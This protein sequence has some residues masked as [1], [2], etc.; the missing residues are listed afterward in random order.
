MGRPIDHGAPSPEGAKLARARSILLRILG[1]EVAVLVLTGIAL[2]FLYRPTADMAWGEDLFTQTVD[3]SVRSAH[4]LRL[5]HRLASI[6]AFPT[7]I[8][9]G[10]LVGLGGRAGVRRGAGVALGV[11]LVVVTLGASFTGYLLPW[12]QLALWAVTV[13]TNLRG[14]TPLFGDEVRFVLIGGV[15]VARTTMVRWLLVHMLVL[16]PAL[17]ALVALAWRRHRPR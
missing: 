5:L 14:F 9:S 3:W 15:E 17:A 12:D 6:V 2:F 8:A 4:G 16:G 13:G 10:V 11:G 7:A 1:A